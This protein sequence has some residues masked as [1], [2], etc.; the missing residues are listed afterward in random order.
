MKYYLIPGK[1][2]D[3]LGV[4]ETVP[5]GRRELNRGEAETCLRTQLSWEVGSGYL[6]PDTDPEEI[7]RSTFAT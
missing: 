3:R 1:N 6:D 2:F 5:A 4:S 7:V